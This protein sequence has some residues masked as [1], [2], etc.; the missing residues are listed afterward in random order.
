MTTFIDT[1][2]QHKAD[3]IL[4]MAS[5]IGMKY[6]DGVLIAADTLGSFG[7][8]AMVHDLKRIYK[9]GKS[10]LIAASGEYSDFTEMKEKLEKKTFDI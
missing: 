6:K 1:P 10:T 4:G 5:V 9:I 3:V 2:I 8:M 7:S